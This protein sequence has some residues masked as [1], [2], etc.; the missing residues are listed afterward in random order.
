MIDVNDFKSIND[1][2]GH[3]VGNLALR[4]VAQRLQASIRSYDLCARYAGDEFVVVL[5][6]C[7]ADEARKKARFLQRAVADHRF[8][9]AG[10]VA[11]A[12]RISVGGAVFPN[13]GKTLDDL[14]SVADH[15]MFRDKHRAN[16]GATTF[17]NRDGEQVQSEDL[18]G[19]T[20]G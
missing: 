8:E 6:G 12:L 13:D 11:V 7:P 4:H 16:D 18:A 10:G 19:V 5:P 2:Y 20:V 15:E 3:S 9:P 14:L 17:A 1:T